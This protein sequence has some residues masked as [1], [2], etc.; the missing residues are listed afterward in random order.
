MRTPRGEYY[1]CKWLIFKIKFYEIKTIYSSV[2]CCLFLPIVF[3]AGNCF[4]Q[5]VV[6]NPA[7]AARKTQ[8]PA[9]DALFKMCHVCLV[10]MIYYF[11]I[12]KPQQLKSKDTG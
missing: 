4:A 3:V 6:S 2:W 11:M 9:G 5:A 1:I 12:I 7:P 10:F 8:P